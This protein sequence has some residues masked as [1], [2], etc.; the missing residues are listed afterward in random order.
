MENYKVENLFWLKPPQ[1]NFKDKLKKS[2]SFKDLNQIAKFSLNTNQLISLSKQIQKCK[3]KF[4]NI[5]KFKLGILGE[6]TT[7]FITSCL[8]ATS[9]RYG[10]DL[11][12][13]ESNF[14][15]I[16]AEILNSNSGLYKN[17]CKAVI[18]ILDIKKNNINLKEQL[19]KLDE[20]TKIL[21]KKG[22]TPILTNLVPD[23]GNIYGSLEGKIKNLKKNQIFS[24]NQG[25]KKITKKYNC[26]LFDVFNLASEI[27]IDK[28]HDYKLWYSAKIP[29]NLDLL[30]I[31]SDYILRL[32]NATKGKS[33]KVLVLDLDNTLWGGVIGDD[34]VENIKIGNDFPVSEAF[35][36]FQ[37][38]ILRFKEKGVVL[39]VSSKNLDNIA[40]IP[41]KERKEMLLKEKDFVAFQANFED[42]ASNIKLIA[43]KLSLNLDSFV[44]FDDN[45]AER[46]I[47]E[48]MLPT[49]TV[50]NV[51]EDPAY[52]AK[53]LKCSGY[54]ETIQFTK[55]DKQRVKFYAA[56]AKRAVL[57]FK[58]GNYDQ[59][60][61][62]LK[63][64]IFHHE[65]K[66]E[67]LERIT[68]LINKTNQFN[69]RTMRYSEIEV[70]KA[71]KNKKTYTLQSKLVD[72][73]GDNGIISLII[74]SEIKKE[75]FIDTWLMSCRV[76]KRDV[77][78]SVLNNIVKF[79]QKKGIKTIIGEYIESPKN[80]LVEN[81]YSDLN[82]IMK[83]ENKSKKSKIYHLDV[84]KFKFYKT[85]I[86]TN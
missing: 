59:Y 12:I 44:F 57:K 47:V 31:Y 69:L 3:N 85:Q 64:N 71:I 84:K 36:N 49:V 55:E 67:S 53:A 11:D 50:I 23:V 18:I 56:D 63:M 1:K 20:Y 26:I 72:K 48:Q 81:H 27:G 60:L 2:T 6:V 78:K 80:K 66:E 38:N 19:I 83:K 4:K 86:M 46:Q 15:S 8:K 29:F 34:G 77:E 45:P 42:K 14:D 22:I 75:L 70:K 37:K 52:F 9:M 65:F 73:F 51:P 79:A 82:F 76:L 68:Q 74:A 30:P 35:Y 41:F 58:I 16:D 40:R 21:I 24:F 17:K 33:K 13:Y 7:D 62:S 28:W 5:D 10:F 39:T 25:I 61:R 32:I 43:E 54:F